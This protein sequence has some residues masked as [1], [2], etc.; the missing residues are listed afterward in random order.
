MVN[1][2]V[3]VFH[4]SFTHFN[5]YARLMGLNTVIYFLCFILTAI[6]ECKYYIVVYGYIFCFANF[7]SYTRA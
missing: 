6:Q 1:C 7:N 4:F 2:N 3:F 5:S